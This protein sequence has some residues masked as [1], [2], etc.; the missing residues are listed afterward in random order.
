MGY[1]IF[2]YFDFL[3]LLCTVHFYSQLG[4][5]LCIDSTERTLLC[6]FALGYLI[7]QLPFS[8]PFSFKYSCRDVITVSFLGIRFVFKNFENTRI[9][10]TEQNRNCYFFQ[11]MYSC[12]VPIF[13]NIFLE[14]LLVT[15][16]L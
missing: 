5:H 11:I 7:N 10:E 4:L 14:I 15:L 2:I 16:F 8:I 6:V 9:L 12:R 13:K 1:L 3:F